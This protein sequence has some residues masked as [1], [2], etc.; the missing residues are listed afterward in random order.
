MVARRVLAGPAGAQVAVPVPRKGSWKVVE[1]L[2]RGTLLRVKTALADGSTRTVKC[3]VHSVDETVLVCGHWSTPRRYPYRVYS[4]TYPDRYVFP[5]EQVVEVRLENEDEER[6]ESRLAG[7]T[8][9][10]ILGGVIGYNCCSQGY[11]GRPGAA[12]VLS[13]IGALTGG[14]VGHAIPFVKGRVIYRR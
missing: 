1:N 5:R 6:T 4:P 14:A 12:G 7:A 8:A 9:G 11:S 3:Q 13:L 10:G 2:P